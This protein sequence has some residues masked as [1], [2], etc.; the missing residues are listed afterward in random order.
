MRTLR[1]AFVS[2]W[3]SLTTSPSRT[4]THLHAARW[5]KSGIGSG[6]TR[7]IFLL[8]AQT[9][10]AAVAKRA[11]DVRM[12]RQRAGNAQQAAEL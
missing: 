5:L 7:L 11:T 3:P 2:L 8:E 12:S 10:A 4:M 9:R 1:V 6:L